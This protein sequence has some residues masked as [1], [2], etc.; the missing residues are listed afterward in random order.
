MPDRPIVLTADEVRET[1]AGRMSHILRP[2]N[3]QPLVGD[4]GVWYPKAPL[5]PFGRG[6]ERHYA[7]EEHMRRGLHIDF[8]PCASGD[9][10]WVRETWG[11]ASRP[12]P[13][14]GWRDG[15]EY[16]ADEAFLEGSDL[17]RLHAVEPPDSVCLDSYRPGWHS[18]TSMPRWAARLLL[19]VVA[20]RVQRLQEVT[21][22]QAQAAGVPRSESSDPAF[23]WLGGPERRNGPRGG[24]V[25]FCHRTAREALATLWS[26][27]Y[28]AHAPWAA[29]PWIWDITVKRVED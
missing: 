16:R 10:L 1:L 7:H 27:R 2:M 6:R 14:H 28:G 3:P 5:Q 13:I 23:T 20:V 29:N 17:L 9:K 4:S 12:D 15:I 11:A 25:A 24:A 21:E 26:H 18:S 22:E 8:G 19:N